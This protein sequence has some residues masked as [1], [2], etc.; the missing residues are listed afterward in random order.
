V[1]SIPQVEAAQAMVPW[2]DFVPV[3]LLVTVLPYIA[4]APAQDP[5]PEQVNAHESPEQATFEAQAPS[6]PQVI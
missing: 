3:Q 5:F 6:P 1:Q 2:H 4:R